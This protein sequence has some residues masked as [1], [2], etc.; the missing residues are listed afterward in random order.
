MSERFSLWSFLLLFLLL[1]VAGTAP[2]CAYYNTFY[3]TK[4]LYRQALKAREK[5]QGDKPTSAELKAYDETIKKASKVL[6]NYPDSKYIDDALMIL[7]E[8]LYYKGDY[9]KARRKFRELLTLFPKSGYREG[10]RLWL[11]KSDLKVREFAESETLLRQILDTS[12]KKKI[13][14]EAQLLLGD[15][16]L[17][18]EAY[19]AAVDAYRRAA[20]SGGREKRARASFHLGEALLQLDQPQKAVE[21]FSKAGRLTREH[22]LRSKARFQE[23]VA[24]KLAGRFD[25][26]IRVFNGLLADATFKNR[27]PAAKLQIADCLRGKGELDKAIQWYETIIEDHPR[28]A[29]SAEAYFELGRMYEKDLKDFEAAKKHYDRVRAEYTAS[30]WADEASQRSRDITALLRLRATVERMERRKTGTAPGASAGLEGKNSAGAD[31]MEAELVARRR[32]AQARK[33]KSAAPDTDQISLKKEEVL[34]SRQAA[35]STTK[36]STPAADTVGQELS[37]AQRE[38]L[39]KSKMQLAELYLLEYAEV[40]SA[41]RQYVDI[42]E[43]YPDHPAAPRALYA[44]AYALREFVGDSVLADSTLRFLV[45]RYPE[46]EQALAV[47]KQLGVPDTVESRPEELYRLAE[48]QLFDRND[49]QSALRTYQQVVDRY[50]RSEYAAKALYAIAY[51]HEDRLFDP[52]AALAEYRKLADAYPESPYG[53]EA[54]RKIQAVE[55]ARKAALAGTEAGAGAASGTSGG[56]LSAEGA[57]GPGQQR[58]RG[59]RPSL[60]EHLE[61][62]GKG[63]TS[64]RRTP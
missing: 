9:L 24:L 52:K 61:K 2:S 4:K 8:C 27:Y 15:L 40:D 5:R 48:T 38:Q 63:I 39:I 10:A 57:A 20:A 36:N 35:T 25:A 29:A 53:R 6:T 3:N 49:P 18:Q 17:E 11:A 19:E 64:E 26:A 54:A 37:E 59:R 22:R 14:D 33:M 51:I 47:A 31:G 43:R 50:P 23:G 30:E 28:T 56:K 42:V 46:S 32:Q 41:M 55:R 16:Y 45:R 1:L 58:R 62:L 21:A 34:V 12:K 13:R 44:I 60:R 7:G